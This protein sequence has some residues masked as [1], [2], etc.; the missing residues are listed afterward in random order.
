MKFF[1]ENIA[2]QILRDRGPAKV[3]PAN[4]VFAHTDDLIEFVNGVKKLLADDGIF[5]FEVSY[6]LDVYEKTLFDMT[7]HE[8]LSYHSVFPLKQFFMSKGLQLIHVERV[9]THGGS[10]RGIVQWAGA[11]RPEND[12]V[13]NLIK[14]ELENDFPL[15]LSSS[16]TL[17][18]LFSN[19][20]IVERSASS[21]FISK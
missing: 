17:E 15:A 13:E 20:N 5:V 4:N 18:N 16:S 3:I 6:L 2:T 10:L 19:F 1:N 7:Y 12:S 14:L 21:G 11:S 8:H 9:H